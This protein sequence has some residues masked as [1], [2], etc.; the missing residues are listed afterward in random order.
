MNWGGYHPAGGELDGSPSALP[1]ATGNPNTRDLAWVPGRAYRLAV[2]PAPEPGPGG[3]AAWRGSVQDLADG[4]IV[5]VRDLWAPGAEV[6]DP[7]V[8]TEAF[9][10]CDHPVT[11]VAWSDLAVVSV[12]GDRVPV[13]AVR[14]SYQAVADGGC[15]TSDSSLAEGVVV[16]ATGGERVTPAGARLVLPGG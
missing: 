14:T 12:D 5:V 13:T 6:V 15:A 2:T 1:S 10:D 11:V 9:T 16:Q 3:V 4:S 7:M 8:W